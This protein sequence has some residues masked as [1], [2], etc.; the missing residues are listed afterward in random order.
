LLPIQK[1]LTE[2]FEKTSELTNFYWPTNKI[3]RKEDNN[4]VV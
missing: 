4:L 3:L 1:N 2:R